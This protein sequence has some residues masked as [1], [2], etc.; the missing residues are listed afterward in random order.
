MKQLRLV[1]V[2]YALPLVFFVLTGSPNLNGES[3]GLTLACTILLFIVVGYINFR[4]V[5]RDGR[6]TRDLLVGSVT[7]LVA[8]LGMKTSNTMASMVLVW[9]LLH[10]ARPKGRRIKL[11]LRILQGV[12]L[13]GLIYL[14]IKG[15][16]LWMIVW[17][18][19]LICMSLF[20][21]GSIIFGYL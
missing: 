10:L 14:G 12:V 4:N 17:S 15:R 8:Y 3:L 2:F 6:L 20:M 11:I 5:V 9:P 21:A 18:I 13:F 16:Q 19:G 1:N 7:L